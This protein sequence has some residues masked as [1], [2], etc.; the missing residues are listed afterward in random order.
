MVERAPDFRDITGFGYL[1]DLEAYVIPPILIPRILLLQ[2]VGVSASHC[3]RATC[4]GPEMVGYPFTSHPPW[5]FF[6]LT[7]CS[8]VKR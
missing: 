3:H 4:S 5:A 8:P 2:E 6:L 1:K 7:T